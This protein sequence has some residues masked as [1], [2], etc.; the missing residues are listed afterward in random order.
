MMRDG[1]AAGI[2]VRPWAEADFPAIQRLSSAAGW[3]TPVERP[4][5]ALAAWRRSR[6]ALVA[7]HG[8]EVVGFLRA[9]SDGEVTTYVAEILVAAEWR[10]RGV[11]SALIE[12]CHALCPRTRLDLLSTA[13]AAPFYRARGFRPFPGFRRGAAERPGANPD[14]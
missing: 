10:D 12:A 6:P 2:A 3:P 5:A 11:G 13:A 1:L 14:R 8:T 9:L 7:T 4:D